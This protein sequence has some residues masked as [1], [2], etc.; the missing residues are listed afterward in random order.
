MADRTLNTVFK[1]RGDSLAN[2][3]AKNAVYADREPIIVIVPADSNS[4]LNEPA[5]LLKIGDGKTA[6]NSLGYVSAIAGDVPAW[7]KEAT[8]PT[9]TATEISGLSD[10]ISGEIKD[11]DTQ[12]KLEQDETDK[13]TLKFFTKGKNDTEYTLAATITTADTVYDDT[14]LAGKV[15]DN[16]DAIDALVKLVGDTAV[17][18]QI[19]NAIT[20]LKLA[21]T[22]E[23]KGAAASALT[24]AKSYA[25]GKDADIKAAKDAADAAQSDVDA[26]E[27]TVGTVDEGKTVVEMIKAA[28]TAAT[29]DDTDV[30]ASI[31]SNADAIATLNGDDTGKSARD[32]SA[33]EVAKIV[34]GADES[35]DT[36]KEIADWIS[37]HKDDASAMNSA[38][39]ALEAIVAG[40]GGDGEKTTVVAY[41]TDAI[42]AL[43]IGD[44]AKAAD[45]TALAERVTTLEGKATNVKKSNTNG[46]IQ[47]DGTDVTVYTL[48][49][50]VLDSGDT[51]VFDGGNA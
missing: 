17:A 2:L 38:I 32:I 49:D 44:Y 4:G 28:Q 51:F 1:L 41:V 27:K 50:T 48:P 8:K 30:K 47:V 20:A 15:S 18:T 34:A 37:S 26:L 29:Y 19:S 6:F 24:E 10:F 14:T 11:T 25:D 39:T 12:Y 43:K 23:A 3:S 21:E 33:E 45:L 9:Y 7:A 40:I 22:Y 16:A 13:H 5:V 31:K 46:N 35:L 36:L 42:D